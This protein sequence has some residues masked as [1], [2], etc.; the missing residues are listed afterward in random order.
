MF[1]GNGSARPKLRCFLTWVETGGVVGFLL[2][3]FAVIVHLV[4]LRANQARRALSRQPVKGQVH[5]P[6]A[7]TAAVTIEGIQIAV[8]RP[9]RIPVSPFDISHV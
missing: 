9:K 7:E 6:R 1:R 4:D 8:V 2:A 3:A 5:T